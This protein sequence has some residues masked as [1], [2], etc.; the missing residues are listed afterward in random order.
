MLLYIGPLTAL[1]TTCHSETGAHTGGGNP[2]PSAPLPK[3]G[4]HGEA[5]TGGFLTA[6]HLL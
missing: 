2:F 6:L 5:V 1:F 4:W 3:G